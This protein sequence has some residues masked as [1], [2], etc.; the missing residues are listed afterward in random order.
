MS[1][2]KNI[3]SAFIFLLLASTLANAQDER[4]EEMVVNGVIVRAIIADGDTM[5]YADFDS[6]TVSSIRFESRAYERH[7]LRMKLNADRVYPYAEKAIA[8]FRKIQEDTEDMRNRDRRRYIRDLQREV[9]TDFEDPLKS[10]TKTQG[11]ILIKM[12]ER[13]LEVPCYDILKEV[14]GGLTAFYWQNLGTFY[15]YDL[16]QGYNPKDDPMLEFVL[17]DL[18]D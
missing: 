17:R 13:E 1:N 18:F 12:I 2:S 16:R 11:K 4:I 15:G 10:L 3:I 9:K 5:Y 8:L 6:L 14:R 7:Y